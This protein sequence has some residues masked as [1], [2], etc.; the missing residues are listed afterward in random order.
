MESKKSYNIL[1]L[2]IIYPL[3]TKENKGTSV[4]HYFTKEW[5]K[6]GYNVRAVH[7]Q[8]VYPRPFYWIAKLNAKRIAAKTGAIVYTKRL[9]HKENYLMDN[10]PVMRVPVFKPIPHGKFSAKSIRKAVQS[11][12]EDSKT[13][14]FVPDVIVGHFPNPQIEMLGLLKNEYPDV[15]TCIVMHGDI[16]IMIKVYRERLPELMKDIDMW[17]FRSKPVLEEFEAAVGM[18]VNPF[19][20]YSGIPESYITGINRHDFTKPLRN[21]VYVGLMIDR[22]YP[23]KVLDALYDVYKNKE[24]HLTYIGE[25]QQLDLIREKMGNYGLQDQVSILGRIPRDTIVEEYDKADCMVMISRGEAYGLVYLEAMARGCITIASRR[26][27]FDGVIVDGENGFLCNAGDAEE[28]SEVIKRINAMPVA[29]RQRI[30]ENAIATAKR[31][32]DQKV[33]KMYIDDIIARS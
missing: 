9:N 8:A 28:L 12:V 1:L 33:A 10:V 14:G 31:L 25:G 30:S 26:E 17:G 22:K 23:E 16:G 2:S 3:P 6:M 4:C 15:K 18:V 13:N 29:E 5:V 24:F 32:T 7:V 27:G 21:F 11:I 19:I 20:C